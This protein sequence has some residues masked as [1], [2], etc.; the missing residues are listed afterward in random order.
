MVNLFKL[1]GSNVPAN[2]SQ[3]FAETSVK[4][5]LLRNRSP[6]SSKDHGHVYQGES[7]TFYS[8]ISLLYL[9]MDS[10]YKCYS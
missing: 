6:N 10:I 3:S 7:F 9:E 2:V 1:V 4:P 8:F 5:S